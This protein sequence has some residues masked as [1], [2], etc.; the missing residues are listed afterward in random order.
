M[1]DQDSI[2]GT[3]GK[4]TIPF[5]YQSEQQRIARKR[6][7]AQMMMQKGMQ[8]PRAT[9]M[10]GIHASTPGIGEHV[11]SALQTYMGMKGQN[12]ADQ[13]L[14]DMGQRMQGELQGDLQG[15]TGA[16][17][18]DPKA[19]IA[20]ALASKFGQVQSLGS[21]WAKDRQAATLAAGNALAQGSP[22]AGARFIQ[23][24]QLEA[25]IADI[26][27]AKPEL[28][29]TPS[30]DTMVTNY[31]KTGKGTS[32]F[33]PRPATTTINNKLTSGVDEDAAKY[34]NYGGKGYEAAV[35]AIKSLGNTESLLA[36]L[37]KDPQMGAGAGGMQ[38]MRKWA[39]TLGLP[40]SDKTTPTEMA[41]MQL[42]QKTLDRLGGLGAQVSDSDRKF[43]LETQGSLAND[44]EAV[45]RMLLIEA[46]YLMQLSSGLNEQ[47]QQV[48]GRVPGM[49]LP[50]HK[51]SFQPSERNAADLERLFSGQGFAPPAAAAVKQ[52]PGRIRSAK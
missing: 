5:E 9:Q 10:F 34:F 41:S 7:L 16:Y 42:G 6:A 13:D 37:D 26:P 15:A 11:L 36:T 49:V 38:V 50:S 4:E 8:G 46:K 44:P 33:A 18:T 14:T 52:Y 39:E 24:G 43:M 22:E 45:R 1:A 48:A 25:P 2:L 21:Q 17:G 47:G 19:G 30:G 35:G 3:S 23:G 20:R 12:Q 27:N 29:T 31:D 51:F 40:I 28:T 32:V